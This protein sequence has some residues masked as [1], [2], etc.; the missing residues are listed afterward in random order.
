M[1][2]KKLALATAAAGALIAAAPAFANP[3]HWAPAHGWRAEHRHCHHD[4]RRQPVVVV[5][6]APYYY[7]PPRPVVVYQPPVYVAP[8]RPVIVYRQPGLSV[9]F[10][11]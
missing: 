4:V 7:V 1:L 9:S 2:T 6:P 10:G 8:P 3:P 11:R 5:Q